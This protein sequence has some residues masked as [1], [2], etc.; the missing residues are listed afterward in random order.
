M[1][2]RSKRSENFFFNFL[3]I[4]AAFAIT[5][6]AVA[7]GAYPKD[8]Y[9]F[10]IGIPSEQKVK[11]TRRIE[12]KIATER[13]RAEAERDAMDMKPLTKKDPQI[14][15]KVLQN[16]TDFMAKID[17]IR[18][19]YQRQEA[20]ETQVQM[21]SPAPGEDMGEQGG[22][23]DYA[24]EPEGVG[25]VEGESFDPEASAEPPPPT[26]IPVTESGA[27]LIPLTPLEQLRSLQ[28]TLSDSQAKLFL[29]LD[30][31]TYEKLKVSII[32]VLDSVLNQGVLEVDIKT[33][34]NIQEELRGMDLNSDVQ[35]IGYQIAST[36][37]EPNFVVDQEATEKARQEIASQYQKVEILK[38]QTIV[39]DGEIISDEAYAMLMDLGMVSQ[40]M[41]EKIPQMLKVVA[42]DGILFAMCI[43]YI[44]IYCKDLLKNKKQ[45]GLLFTIYSSVMV[46][47]SLLSKVP[48]QFL[49]IFIFTL[50]V[51][52]LINMNL[53][54]VLNMFM[55]L[56]AMLI[57]K[58]DSSFILFFMGGGLTTALLA[59]HTAERNHV[60]LVGIAISFVNFALMF[61]IGYLARNGY[62]PEVLIDA[63]YAAISGIF[64]VILCI[65]SLPFWEAFFGVVTNIKLMDLTN[66]S[67]ALMRRMI[68]EAPGTYHHSLVVANL[69]ETAACDIGADAS[70]A[71]AGGYYHDIGKLKH[72][73]YFVENLIGEN[74]HNFIEPRMSAELIISHVKY[75]IELAEEHK[76]PNIVR[77]IIVEHHGTTLIQ[78]FYCKEKDSCAEGETVNADDF[79]Y[80]FRAPQFKESGIVMLAD[81]VEAAVRSMINGMRNADDLVASI[82]KLIKG[83]LDDGQ[84]LESQLSIKDL[85]VIAMSFAKVFNGMYHE[86]IPY[87]K[88]T[89]EEKQD[90][91]PPSA[92]SKGEKLK[93]P[94]PKEAASSLG[95]AAD[96]ATAS[97]ESAPSEL[98]EAIAKAARQ[99]S[100][101]LQAAASYE[102]APDGA[103][104][105]YGDAFAEDGV[106]DAHAGIAL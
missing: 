89:E 103:A 91:K 76:L 26:S 57:T 16:A 64:T 3:L 92:A 31:E 63:G 41:H 29:S 75:G 4:A 93:A 48:Y 19:D 5:A 51:S 99:T 1:K 53:G 6:F 97:V 72:P 88:I 61:S 52:M 49:P 7:T 80:P 94:S 50:L 56:T 60:F 74:P 46:I 95:M 77:D 17:E 45:A 15:E 44:F 106:L 36:F 71:R 20:L 85:D 42:V 10:E 67:N 84:L 65:G 33:L 87:P 82:R 62:D 37:I 54:I 28:L 104:D 102:K 12:N 105:S 23:S 35:G 2:K 32:Q 9:I 43:I 96:E 25:S 78:F 14:G 83:K 11:A 18:L 100:E 40:P 13:N 58:E 98:E 39:D 70:L 8:G 38:D 22:E 55:S 90:A 101:A 79:R 27:P 73:Q 86:R 59:K 30:D 81:T 68:I 24:R 34:L 66:P 47:I 21:P 69:A